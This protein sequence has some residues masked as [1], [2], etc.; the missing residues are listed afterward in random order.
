MMRPGDSF[1]CLY[2]VSPGTYML[3]VDRRGSPFF[4]CTSCGSRTF[5]HG[6]GLAGPQRLWG[7][8]GLALR[9]GDDD[10]ARELIKREVEHAA[11]ETARD[12]GPGS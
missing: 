11:G 4:L 9:A 7:K 6:N 8:L 1:D 12:P 2:C 5:I 10:V 3:K